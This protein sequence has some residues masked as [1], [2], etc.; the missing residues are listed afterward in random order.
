MIHNLYLG[1]I[2]FPKSLAHFE[3][4]CLTITVCDC[5]EVQHTIETSQAVNPLARLHASM[6]RILQRLKTM[7]IGDRGSRKDLVRISRSTACSPELPPPYEWEWPISDSGD[8][9]YPPL[10]ESPSTSAFREERR[11]TL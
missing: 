3:I 10:P 4:M 9:S 5:N 8:I 1:S 7:I 6:E 11:R 2:Q